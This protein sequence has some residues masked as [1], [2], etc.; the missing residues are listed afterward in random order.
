MTKKITTK[1]FLN[2]VLAGG[3]VAFVSTVA[4][5]SVQYPVKFVCCCTLALIAALL[6][7]RLAGITGT[8]TANYVFVLIGLADL[9]RP[10]S[11][12]VK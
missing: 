3:A 1:L 4:R 7:V 6:K 5:L 10:A 9:S 8:L 12:Q 11:A 2:G